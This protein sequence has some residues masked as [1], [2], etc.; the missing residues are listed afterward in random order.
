MPRLTTV[1]PGTGGYTRRRAGRGFTYWG[2]NGRRITHE[3]TLERIRG[4]AIPPA[5]TQVWI[6]AED[7]A[8]IQ[9]TGVDD[10]GRTQY[11]YHPQWR[12]ARDAEKFERSLSF[13][14]TLPAV[15]RRVTRDLKPAGEQDEVA[16]RR[17]ALAAAVRLMDR[18]ALRVG[19]T[20]HTG[21]LEAF[22]AA[23]LQRRHVDVDGPQVHL[24]FRGKSGSQW[25]L[26]LED[27]ALAEF[28][29]AV[30]ATPRKA[31][32]VCYP[33]RSGRRR[34][35]KGI[36]AADV[37]QYLKDLAGLE[38]TAKDFRTWQGTLAAARSLARSH[39]SGSTSPQAVTIAIKAAAALLH[40]TP[41]VAR[42]SYV[43]PRVVDLFE[44]GRVMSLRGQ[45]DRALLAL[46]TAE[47]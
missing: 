1:T 46:M 19:G 21:E 8:H 29:D 4:L 22:G 11:L 18:G 23:T 38:F 15:R 27:E 35:W 45:P 17:R 13:G 31:A 32:A 28:F 43:D 25:D 7:N 24:A 37:N 40:N 5:W 16:G 47:D 12:Q 3:D 41:T 36:S 34:E 33:V 10:A 2:A 39:R 14:R 30:P 9:A 6:A 42:D 20:E 44:K 26:T